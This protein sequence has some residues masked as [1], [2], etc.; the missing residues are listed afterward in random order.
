[1]FILGSSIESDLSEEELSDSEAVIGKRRGGNDLH[2]S[3]SEGG[4]GD[5]SESEINSDD[6]FFL[7]DS[8][9]KI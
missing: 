6:E 4:D 3:G 7:S 1:M 2:D 5:D 8:E 9:V